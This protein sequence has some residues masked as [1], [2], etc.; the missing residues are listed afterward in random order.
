MVILEPYTVYQDELLTERLTVYTV[1]DDK[2]IVVYKQGKSDREMQEVER[3]SHQ[4]GVIPVN[5]F[6]STKDKKSLLGDDFITQQDG[7]NEV[8]SANSDDVK[9]N[10]DAFLKITGY[11][12]E[13]FFIK[14]ENGETEAQKMKKNRM[15][16]LGEGANA[17]YITKGNEVNKVEFDLQLYR[18]A[19]HLMGKV[20]D[21]MGKLLGATGNTSGI[22]LKLMFTA[23]L[24]ASEVFKIYYKQALDR[25]ID[26]FNRWSALT[27]K[28][29]LEDY[30]IEIDV[31][32]PINEIEIWQNI[33]NL[34]PYLSEVD[35]LTLIP[36]VKDPEEAWLRKKESQG[37]EMTSLNRGEIE[38]V[39]IEDGEAEV[40]GQTEEQ[41]RQERERNLTQ[42]LANTLE[43]I[44]Q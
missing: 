6:Y 13:S 41:I 27:K 30:S 2:E 33:G 38:P 7:Y 25:R 4:F 1:Y 16:I 39:E 14:D 17:E 15:L 21:V 8:R 10:V 28:P 29:L 40:G 42:S 11:S 20:P 12:A 24:K 23:Q 43:D 44:V 31:S 36:S 18:D 19:I 3:G 9:H 5:P 32:I 26:I 35:L 37:E 22:A 34:D